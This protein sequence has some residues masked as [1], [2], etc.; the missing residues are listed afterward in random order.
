MPTE[1]ILTKIVSYDK[2]ISEIFQN[3]FLKVHPEPFRVL[4]IRRRHRR[5][6]GF[7]R[8]AL[9]PVRLRGRDHGIVPARIMQLIRHRHCHKIR[10]IRGCL[11]LQ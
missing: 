7:Q 11:L 5:S 6:I 8:H 2:R 9:H 1:I 10:E 4:R 3:R